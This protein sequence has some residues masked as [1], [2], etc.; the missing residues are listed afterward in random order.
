MRKFKTTILV[1]LLSIIS[2]HLKSQDPGLNIRVVGKGQPVVLIPGLTCSGEVWDSTIE[3]LDANFEYHIITLPGFAGNAPL[4]DHEGKYLAKMKDEVV[5]YIQK[6]KLKKPIIIGHSLGGFLALNIGIQNPDLPSK[7]VIVDALPFMT[8]VM[9]PGMT[10]EEAKPMAKSMKTQVVASAS[11]P[12]EGRKAYQRQM[13][14]SM[15]NDPAQIE[16]ATQWAID[17]DQETVG[18]SMYEMYTTDIRGELGKIKV[19]TLVLG[20]W[21]AYQPMGSTRESTLKLYTDQYA[22]LKGVQVDMTDIGN[23]FIMWD[24]PEF[25]QNWLKKFL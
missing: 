17:S 14:T 22:N 18:E 16:I 10:A 23:H 24:D 7:L 5:K 1:T 2:F 20:A 12:L 11:Q 15:I 25:F 19:P 8:G 13:L 6:E 9:M 4:A 21:V 3:A